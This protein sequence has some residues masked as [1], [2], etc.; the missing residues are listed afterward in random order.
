MRVPGLDATEANAWTTLASVEAAAVHSATFPSRESEYGVYFRQFLRG[1]LDATGVAYA[2]ATIARRR[3]VG[4]MRPLFGAI[5]LLAC[6]TLAAEPFRYDP[7]Q[8]YEGLDPDSGTICGVPADWFG[9]SGPFITIWDFN[10]YPTLSLPCGA[11]DDGIPL[12]LQL[13]GSP[14]LEPALCRAGHALRAG[15][16]VAP[17]ASAARLSGTGLNAAIRRAA[18]CAELWGVRVLSPLP[19]MQRS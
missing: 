12:S 4:R 13:V 14:L 17:A 1:G 7:E 3:A 6:P 19:A 15:D 18:S 8:A 2:E 11:T 9:A 10:G 16:R 5:D